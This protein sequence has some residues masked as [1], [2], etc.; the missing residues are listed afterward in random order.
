MGHGASDDG[1][2]E[3]VDTGVRAVEDGDDVFIVDD[4]VVAAELECETDGEGK[5]PR[6]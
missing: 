4:T 1:E 3:G 5:Q 2:Q 6:K